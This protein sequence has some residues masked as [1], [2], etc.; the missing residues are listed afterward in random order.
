M[1]GK[2]EIE[3]V[4]IKTEVDLDYSWQYEK[5]DD[6]DPPKSS[7]KVSPKKPKKKHNSDDRTE[8]PAWTQSKRK[9][10][11]RLKKVIPE[12]K[13]LILEDK[14]LPYFVDYSRDGKPFCCRNCNDSFPRLST[15][16][17]HIHKKHEGIEVPRGDHVAFRCPDCEKMFFKHG[18]YISHRVAHTDPSNQ[19]MFIC[20][21]C[22]RSFEFKYMVRRHMVSLH[23]AATSYYCEP[24]NRYFGQKSHLVRHMRRHNGPKEYKCPECELKFKNKFLLECHVRNHNK[25]RPFKCHLCRKM[26]YF[27]FHL[28][29]HL[30]AHFKKGG[31]QC[32]VCERFFSTR[33]NLQRHYVIHG[34]KPDANTGMQCKVC[35]TW[36]KNRHQLLK[37]MKKKHVTEQG[38]EDFAYV[39]EIPAYDESDSIAVNNFDSTFQTD[40]SFVIKKE[41]KT[42]EA[43]EPIDYVDDSITKVEIKIEPKDYFETDDDESKVDDPIEKNKYMYDVKVESDLPDS[44]SNKESK[45]SQLDIVQFIDEIEK[46]H[47]CPVCSKAFKFQSKLKTHMGIHNVERPHICRVC[48]MSFNQERYLNQHMLRHGD[49]ML[50]CKLCPKIFKMSKSLNQH[51][52]THYGIKPYV[53]PRC[54]KSFTYPKSL[55]I[56]SRVHTGV[57]PYV[58]NYC[59]RAFTMKSGLQ[60]H[61]AVHTLEK[62]FVCD[63]CEKCFPAKYQLRRHIIRAHTQWRPFKCDRCSTTFTELNLLNRHIDTV[64]FEGAAISCEVCTRSYRNQGSL[65][66]HIARSPRCQNSLMD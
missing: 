52:K 40:D 46:P 6:K 31:L 17:Q 47:K 66:R 34:E 63:Y 28:Q 5:Y 32:D 56:H 21:L 25:E 36:H 4:H 60:S 37:H 8:S 57:R 29:T 43:L 10:N 55:E 16:M 64:H 51:V 45:V 22:G 61:L 15:L 59:E 53:C 18:P 19:K 44:E 7:R 54:D 48:N 49:K 39:N 2:F 23:S 41:I 42:E 27:E 9:A 58:C 62:P 1:E 50:R 30:R 13:L 26:Y 14:D 11:T 24:C 38:L 35:S 3:T 65:A 20:D 33:S 12:D